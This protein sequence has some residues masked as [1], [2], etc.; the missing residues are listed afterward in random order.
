[1][2]YVLKNAAR[3]WSASGEEERAASYGRVV[4]ALARA[5]PP[6]RGTAAAARGEG[7]A[8]GAAAAAAGGAGG[9]F[10]PPRV[11]VPGSGLGRLCVD[12]VAAGY[13]AQGN[14]FSYYMLL[15]SAFALNFC[16]GALDG[17]G[18][19]RGGGG[20][21]EGA[22]EAGAAA[23]GGRGRPGGGGAPPPRKQ[24]RRG[25]SGA[26]RGTQ[27]RSRS[28]RARGRRPQAHD[29]PLGAHA[30]QLAPRRG[31]ASRG[32][33]PGHRPG[34]R[35][36]RGGGG[37]ERR[38]KALPPTSSDPPSP[39]FFFFFFCCCCCCCCCCFSSPPRP[40]QHY[41]LLSMVA[42]DFA[43]VYS[44][45]SSEGTFDAVATCFFLDTAHNVLD[46]IETIKH[47]LVKN[48]KGVWVELGPL[49]YHWADAASYLPSGEAE[50]TL[51]LELPLDEVL[52]AV[53]AAGFDVVDLKK[54]SLRPSTRRRARCC[55]AGTRVRSGPRY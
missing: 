44:H 46:Y 23:E 53:A 13:A 48:G 51:S 4:E 16:C 54:D 37:E 28:E 25:G 24:R 1:M 15:A 8:A 39:S 38:R 43:Q 21:E 20:G 18:G 11:L 40:S 3:D 52:L 6:G 2:R 55:G 36:R 27:R 14:E 41:P 35:R 10:Q 9:G 7:G 26:P 49:L 30:L 47:V 42:G 45:R 29:P 31:P 12:L 22:E 5:L 34:G 50:E 17:G 32:A 33:R 19:G